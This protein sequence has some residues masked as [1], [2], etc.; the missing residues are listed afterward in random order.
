MRRNS[1]FT[2]VEILTAIVVVTILVAMAA[3]L[4]EKTVERS[5]LAEARTVLAKL[6]DAK[7]QAMDN[8]DCKRYDSSD[9]TCPKLRHL[10]MGVVANEDDTSFNSDAFRFSLVLNGNRLRNAVCARRTGGDGQG[11]V[12]VYAAPGVQ[13]GHSDEGAI[14]QCYGNACRNI[15]G[16]PNSGTSPCR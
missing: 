7:L 8:M 15:Y 9:P 11:T 16:L 14:F 6:Q 5:R 2:L 4:Y 3:P 12:F 10:S 1:G 13:V